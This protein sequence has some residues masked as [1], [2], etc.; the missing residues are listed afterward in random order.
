MFL[1]PSARVEA[2]LHPLTSRRRSLLGQGLGEAVL[3]LLLLAR[4][5]QLAE[6][7][8]T[9]FAALNCAPGATYLKT[10]SPHDRFSQRD[11]ALK[12][13]GER[14]GMAFKDVIDEGWMSAPNHPAV[15]GHLDRTS[16]FL[17]VKSIGDG[18]NNKALTDMMAAKG[19]TLPS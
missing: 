19:M 15:A 14:S 10:G 9:V 12:G 13:K 18:K 3:Q 7:K 4:G 6:Q 5:A 1:S 2:S 11:E 17:D 16:T 8:G